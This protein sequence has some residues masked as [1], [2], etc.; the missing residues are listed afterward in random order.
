MKELESASMELGKAVY[1]AAAQTAG[2]ATGA[3]GGQSPGKDDDVID[4][5]FKVKE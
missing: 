4:A 5:E 1:E 3:E 2:A